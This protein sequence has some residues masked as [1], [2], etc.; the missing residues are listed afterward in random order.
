[1]VGSSMMYNST[2]VF[3][4]TKDIAIKNVNELLTYTLHRLLTNSLYLQL[5]NMNF[6]SNNQMITFE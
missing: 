2:R 5:T 1:M 4:K 3:F 6:Y